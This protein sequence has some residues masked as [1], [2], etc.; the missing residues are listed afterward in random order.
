LARAVAEG[1]SSARL[2]LMTRA[3]PARRRAPV[4]R[5]AAM[6]LAAV[7]GR[8]SVGHRRSGGGRDKR[9][10]RDRAISPVHG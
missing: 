6:M 4:G 2:E 8:N 9:V 3:R 10:R 5:T 1:V 7:L